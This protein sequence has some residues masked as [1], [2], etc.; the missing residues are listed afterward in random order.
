MIT[1]C[2]E[3]SAH[4]VLGPSTPYFSLLL[5]LISSHSSSGALSSE[6]CADLP[7]PQ[8]LALTGVPTWSSCWSPASPPVSALEWNLIWFRCPA[9]LSIICILDVYL[10]YLSPLPASLMHYAAM[11]STPSLPS[12][13]LPIGL[14]TCCPLFLE[15]SALH[16]CLA[17]WCSPE[18]PPRAPPQS[19][20]CLS[21]R[22]VNTTSFL[23]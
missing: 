10:S 12:S 9:G 21:S 22:E 2:S 23:W 3:F 17:G 14:C 15:C 11:T 18:V 1:N 6:V 8:P 4:S 16:L 20:H 13:F 5:T 7:L 19:Q